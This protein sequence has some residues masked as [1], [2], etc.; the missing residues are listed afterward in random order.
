MAASHAFDVAALERHLVGQMPG[1]AGPLTVEQFKGGQSNPT[2]R[3]LTPG[4][5]RDAQQ[6]RAGWRS[7][8]RRRMPSSASS[9]S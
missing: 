3:L 7:C 4:A 6:A 9:A 5:L 2:Y 8:C 1:F